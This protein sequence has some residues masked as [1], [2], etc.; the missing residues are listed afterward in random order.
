MELEV[1]PVSAAEADSWIKFARRILVEL[2]TAP[3][4]DDLPASG[5]VELWSQTIDTW[6]DIARQA[7]AGAVPFR[8]SCSYE[9]EFG[10]YLLHGLEQCLLS[11]TVAEWVRPEEAKQQLPFTLMVVRAFVEGL[12]SEGHS[13]Q[14]YVDQIMAAFGQD[15]EA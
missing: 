6:S 4:V 11:R 9:P 7:T 12:A 13:A 5:V 3:P 15:L 14:H 10:E 8:V 1:G 2:K